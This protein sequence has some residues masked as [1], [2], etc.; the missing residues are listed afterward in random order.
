[1]RK[2]LSR[3]RCG[4]PPASAK[5]A[6]A[7]SGAFLPKRAVLRAYRWPGNVR[8]LENAVEHAVVLGTGDTIRTEDLPE[9]VRESLPADEGEQAGDL[10]QAINA[11]KRGALTRAFETCRNDHAQ[12]AQLLGVH[13][14]YL[15]RLIRNLGMH[16]L[17]KGIARE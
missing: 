4:S 14:N 1:M 11:A 2:T 6:A 15:Y 3:W 17:L 7:P 9:A 8:E 10:Q 12:A 5:N 16:E 13:P